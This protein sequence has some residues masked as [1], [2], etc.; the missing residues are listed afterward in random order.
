MILDE[1][2]IELI[3]EANAEKVILQKEDL[4]EDYSIIYNTLQKDPSSS[5]LEAV[6]PI[7]E[8]VNSLSRQ[9]IQSE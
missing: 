2:N 7:D 3:L 6:T 1:E 8:V 9:T 4:D 5:E